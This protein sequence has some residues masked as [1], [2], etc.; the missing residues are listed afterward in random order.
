MSEWMEF[1]V[2]GLPAPQGSKR[3]FVRNGR[4]NLV[5]MA[6][7][8]LKAWRQDV[9]VAAIGAMRAHDWLTLDEP[10]LV[11]IG[12]CL[13]RPKSRPHDEWHAVRPDIDKL[14]RAVFD[15][16][17]TAKVWR[18]DSNV[19]HLISYKRYATEPEGPGA[20]IAVKALR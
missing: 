16:L 9:T 20:L 4:A 19:A 15:A 17:T 11:D 2:K 10:A 7:A 1:R 5:E 8:S 12:F 13:P 6:G 18:D 3:A 14:V